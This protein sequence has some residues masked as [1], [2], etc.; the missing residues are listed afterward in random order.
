[1]TPAT[2]R[3]RALPGASLLAFQRDPIGFLSRTAARQG[4]VA[5]LRLGPQSVVLLS[6]P[7]DIRDLLVTNNKS[8][9]KG[10]ALERAKRLLGEGLLT[11]EG[12]Y[13]LRQ[14]R[15]VAP[16]FHRQ[17]VAAYGASMARFA[18]EQQAAWQ[19]GAVVDLAHELMRLTLRIAGQ[20]LFDVDTSATA[21]EVY[22]AM[23]DLLA[24]FT[25]VSLPFADALDEL[26]L[27]GTIR[28]RAA[29]ARLDRIIYAMIAERRAS[30]E[31]RGD[32]LSMLLAARDAEGDQGGM[33]DEQV[34]D[35]ALTIFLAGHETTA[36]A[37]SWSFYLLSQRPDV[38]ARLHAELDAVLGGRAPTVDD[39]PQLRFTEQLLAEAMRLYPPAWLLGRRAIEPFTVRGRQY[40]A[41][42]IA[43]TSQWLV[44]HD[45]RFY[46]DPFRFDPERFSPQ[47]RAARPKFAYFPFGGGPRICIGEQ[48]AWLEG[49]LVL[50]AIARR[51]QPALLPGHPV[52]LHPTITLRPRHGLR[53]RLLPRPGV[54]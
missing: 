29:R 4:D 15:L 22:G 24:L 18:D 11:S 8:F 32:L 16:A 9:V 21:D 7:D 53:V 23:H 47:A 30:G 28:F 37:L 35:E 13:H 43:I 38:A 42:T 50:A 3:R 54:L 40:P 20:T 31:D 49:V 2:A 39:L 46:P 48:F 17:R 19:P 51:W 5:E 44:H 26:P 41:G 33:T 14:R 6:H 34:R 52:V 12:A 1:M 36:N 25:V 10:R 45:P 27:P